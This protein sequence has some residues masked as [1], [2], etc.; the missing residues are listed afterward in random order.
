MTVTFLAIIFGLLWGS[1]NEGVHD[2]G[3]GGEGVTE[4]NPAL[5]LYQNPN[6]NLIDIS[7]EPVHKIL[8]VS[9]LY[10]FGDIVS[11]ELFDVMG[12]KLFNGTLDGPKRHIDISSFSPG[13]YFLLARSGQSNQVSRKIILY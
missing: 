5:T 11:L 4:E 7:V 13:I 12:R 9:I 2:L 8:S 6:A 1:G 3:A 10:S